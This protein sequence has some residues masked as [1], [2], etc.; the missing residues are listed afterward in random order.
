MSEVVELDTFSKQ[1]FEKIFEIYDQTMRLH[2]TKSFGWDENVQRQKLHQALCESK[3]VVL[4]YK[5]QVSAFALVATDGSMSK[6]V[7][8]CVDPR[9]QHKGLG[10]QL[11]DDV[12][13]T[14]STELKRLYGIVLPSN[15]VQDFYIILQRLNWPLV[16]WVA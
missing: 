10:R 12:K 7:V 3:A 15:N 4:R 8:M 13:D 14:A 16:F 1:D 6:I 2:I 11:L 9:H 5:G